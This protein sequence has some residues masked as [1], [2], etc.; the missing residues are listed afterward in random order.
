[1]AT[2]SFMHLAT[3]GKSKATDAIIA[4]IR[5]YYPHSYY[6]LGSDGIDDLSEIA[7]KYK[8]DYKFYENRLGYPSYDSKKVIEWLHRFKYACEQC[9]TSHIMMVEDDVWIKKPLTIDDNWQMVGYDVKIGNIIPSNIIKSI[10]TFSGKEP[11]TN[12]Y[13]LGGGSIFKVRTFLDN[14]NLVL[15]WFTTEYD[16]FQK[17]YNPLGYMDCYMLVYYFL[18]GQDYKPNPYYTDSHH[19]TNDGYDYDEFVNNQPEH[20]EIINNYK[21]YYFV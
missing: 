18:C 1:M 4:N 19:H 11:L 21:K 20:I 10:G 5:K 12:Q 13:G 3:A 9:E 8:C 16:T 15:E 14:F 7:N 2:I 17:E 6:F